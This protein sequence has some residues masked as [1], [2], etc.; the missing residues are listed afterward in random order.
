MT[1]QQVLGS[2]PSALTSNFKALNQISSFGYGNRSSLGHH[3][4]VKLQA[5]WN[6]TGTRGSIK[7]VSGGAAVDPCTFSVRPL[8]GRPTEA[9]KD[10]LDTSENLS[11]GHCGGC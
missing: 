3:A 4:G 8:N 7:T 1:F 11:K 10:K 9:A 5:T 6:K 2:S